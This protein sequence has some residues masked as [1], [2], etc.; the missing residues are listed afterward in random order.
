MKSL[1]QLLLLIG[2]LLSMKLV[3]AGEL[4]L[5][6]FSKDSK[7]H[8]YVGISDGLKSLEE[9]KAAA[10]SNAIAEAIK[11]NF[12]YDLKI[13]QSTYSNN[14]GVSAVTSSSS[15]LPKIST[16]GITTADF[17]Y[18][19]KH[20]GTYLVCLKIRYPI[21]AI[22]MTKRQQ[23]SSRSFMNQY[24]EKHHHG[25][26]LVETTPKNSTIELTSLDSRL[27]V[28]G[29]GPAEIHA[30]LGKYILTILSHGYLP[31]QKE[32][33]ITAKQQEHYIVLRKA[34]GI[35]QFETTPMDATVEVN[36]LFIKDRKI[37][38]LSNKEYSI[39]VSHQDYLTQSQT[40]IL[41]QGKLHELSIELRGKSGSVKV[42]ASLNNATIIIDDIDYGK[43]SGKRVSLS[44][45]EHS[46][47]ASSPGFF[48][49]TEY[50]E[51]KANRDHPTVSV[52]LQ[53]VPR[54]YSPTVERN[55]SSWRVS[56]SLSRP[57]FYVGYQPFRYDEKD[58]AFLTD[59]SVN[60]EYF[61]YKNL[62]FT[63]EYI[64]QEWN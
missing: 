47:K 64:H 37:S 9:A 42:A 11:H 34:N 23:T 33:I 3:T 55:P 62:S 27:S 52:Q 59:V 6:A 58:K 63:G 1:L 45:G 14:N 5:E 25:S 61:L 2:L 40:V 10:R 21:A 41:E 31:E 12:S 18:T 43:I 36:G 28:E 19:E 56:S 17:D 26:I 54:E 60:L 53:V 7:N 13:N 46:I 49:E 35:L 20:N 8:Y 16:K 44:P 39:T 38:L 22:K 48:S 29:T 4:C 24:G 32:V 57:N 30:P 15:N 51:I 50:I